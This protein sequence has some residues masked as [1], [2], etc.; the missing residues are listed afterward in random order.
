MGC[1]LSIPPGGDRFRR[2]WMLRDEACREL[3]EHHVNP[4]GQQEMPTLL[5]TTS[6]SQPKNCE[7]QDGSVAHRMEWFEP[8]VSASAKTTM[9]HRSTA[10]R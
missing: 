4:F 9:T 7:I 8:A 10:S 1:P 3:F 5:A 2:R 6:S